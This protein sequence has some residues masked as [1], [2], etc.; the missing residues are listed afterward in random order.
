[1]LSEMISGLHWLAILAGAV[2]YWILGALWYSPALFAKPWARM[3]G[4]KMDDPN[5]KKGMAIMFLGSFVLMFIA[6]TGLALLMHLIP[7]GGP[8]QAAKL[9]LLVSV[10]FSFTSN[11]ISYLY[12]RKPAGLYAIDGGYHVIGTV[13]A[14][15]VIKLLS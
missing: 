6:S 9:G 15:I 3:V 11:A 1:M 7:S 14:A 13:L 4:L 2:A 10:C 5:A 8:A 12:T